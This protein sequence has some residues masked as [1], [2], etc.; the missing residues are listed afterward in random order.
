MK[1]FETAFVVGVNQAGALA[2]RA[3][4]GDAAPMAVLVLPETVLHSITPGLKSH[5]APIT[6]FYLVGSDTV[7]AVVQG[8]VS[9]ERCGAWAKVVF[10]N[11]DPARVIVLGELSSTRYASPNPDPE[12]PLLRLMRSPNF[13][14][15]LV[16]APAVPSAPVSKTRGSS[17]SGGGSGKAPPPPPAPAPPKK[18]AGSIHRPH[19]PYLEPPTVID[20]IAAAIMTLC[21]HR[22]IPAG[23]YLSLVERRLHMESIQVYSKALR[24]LGILSNSSAESHWSST[25]Q[26][27]AA[28]IKGG[29]ISGTIGKKDTVDSLYM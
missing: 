11:F 25:L 10:A 6:Q 15:P 24:A 7:V 19:V 29:V 17:S 12:P 26:S 18:A 3:L 9:E 27:E 1:L 8:P 23:L 22:Q 4:V 16:K 14:T 2:A 21:V 20:G 5:E 28:K 13:T